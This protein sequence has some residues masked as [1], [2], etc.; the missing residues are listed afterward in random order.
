M[1]KTDTI[2]S[3]THFVIPILQ[4]DST[5]RL[6]VFEEVHLPSTSFFNKEAILERIE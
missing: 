5:C 2:Q 3:N 6:D 4:P 1:A